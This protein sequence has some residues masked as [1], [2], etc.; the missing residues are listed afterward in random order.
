MRSSA[1]VQQASVQ[2][3]I[4][5]GPTPAVVLFGIGSPIVVEHAETCRRLGWSIIAAIKNRDGDV[6]FDDSAKIMDA[7]AIASAVLAYPCLCPL[8]T[9]ANRA[10]ATREAKARRFRLDAALIDPNAVV[11]PTA[12][13][14]GGS[15]INTGCIVGSKVSIA[16]HV[17]ANRGASIGHHAR[18]GECASLG[19]GVIVGGLAVIE[20][21]AMIGAGAI[22]LP[23]VRIGAFAVVGAGA[24]VTRD[25]APRSKV[26]G[27]PARAIEADLPEFDLPD[28]DLSSR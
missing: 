27:N 19:P 20:Q 24:V 26:I 23:K 18:I 21:G 17:L 6:Y 12:D 9:P 14:G 11:P 2:R 15:F 7:G 8:F 13:V 28:S 22:V 16:R 1:I 5:D 10:V 3:P 4:D 25:V